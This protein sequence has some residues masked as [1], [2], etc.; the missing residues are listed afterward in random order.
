MTLSAADGN[1]ILNENFAPWVRELGLVVEETGDLMAVLRLPWST[2]LARQGGAMC[3][4]ALMAAADTATV[5]A[6]SAARGEFV[7]MTT[8]QQSSTFQRPVVD[9]DVLVTATLTKVGRTLAF[10][11]VAMTAGG[12][13]AAHA[14]TVYALL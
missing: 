11:E 5:I 2:R 6:V 13:V 7:P 9:A 8:V 12:N 1:A 10:A 4:Q 14:T 3:G